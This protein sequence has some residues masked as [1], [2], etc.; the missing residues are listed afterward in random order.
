[1]TARCIYSRSA[2]GAPLQVARCE[3]AGPPLRQQPS[4]HLRF[5]P[6]QINH[7]LLPRVGG[8]IRRRGQ[9]F[10]YCGNKAILW[11][12]DSQF[13]EAILVKL[14]PHHVSRME[15]VEAAPAALGLRLIIN[16]AR[17]A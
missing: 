1:M 15:Q 14:D 12:A 8:P 2:A 17:A 10:L 6:Y 5:H 9:P 4:A 16:V 7:I 3:C 13:T 11:M